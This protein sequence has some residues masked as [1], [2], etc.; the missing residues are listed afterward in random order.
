MRQSNN[1]PS[2]ICLPGPGVLEEQEVRRL[3]AALAQEEAPVDTEKGHRQRTLTMDR[4]DSDELECTR[5]RPSRCE[6]FEHRRRRSRGLS[7]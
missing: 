6:E 4:D 1:P 3:L 5:E 2:V 7:R